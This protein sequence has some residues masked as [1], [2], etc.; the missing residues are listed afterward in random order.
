VTVLPQSAKTVW[1]P[2]LSPGVYMIRLSHRDGA[3][4]QKIVVR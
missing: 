3:R 2:E 4:T 1:I